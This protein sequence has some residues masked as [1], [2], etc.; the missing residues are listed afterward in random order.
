MKNKKFNLILAL[1][2]AIGAVTLAWG[3]RERALGQGV[4]AFGGRIILVEYCCNGVAITVGPPR[5]GR[6]LLTSGTILYPYYNVYTPG[7]SVLGTAI[8]GG[9]CHE[10]ATACV[11]PIPVAGTVTMIG[12]SGL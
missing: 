8:P 12:S 3:G 5:P 4:L 6:F 11:V 7:P 2:M 10:A 9:I 1:V